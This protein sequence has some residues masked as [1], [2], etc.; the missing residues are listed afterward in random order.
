MLWVAVDAMGGD[1]APRLV[2]DGALAAAR[3][4]DL[5]VILVG[6]T[7]TIERELARH[8]AG[9]GVAGRRVRIVEAGE[10]VAM[11]ESPAAALR[12]KPQA[13][14]RVAADLV[15]RGEAAAL[16]SAGHTGETVMA[17]HAAFGMLPGLDRPALAA[18]IPTR[19]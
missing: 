17:A 19:G 15:A 4:L 11:D 12:R 7:A 2:V 13:S 18:A 8:T 6:P 5:G 14:I 3:H 10:V 9:D 16:F 1:F